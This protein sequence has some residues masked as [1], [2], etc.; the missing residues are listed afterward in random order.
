M[1]NVKSKHCIYDGCIKHPNFNLPTE[2]DG[3]FCVK[4]KLD[5][6]VDVRNKHCSHEGCIKRPNYNLPTEKDALFCA[7]HKQNGML[8]V[9]N[10]QRLRVKIIQSVKN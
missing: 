8:N 10:T 7:E 1:I 4:H 5:G 6:M 9:K 3:K 2:K